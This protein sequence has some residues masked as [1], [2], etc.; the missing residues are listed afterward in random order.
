MIYPNLA[1]E[2]SKSNEVVETV[3]A[4]APC[5][6]KIVLPKNLLVE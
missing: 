3:N 6:G 4:F 2:L 5:L 1:R